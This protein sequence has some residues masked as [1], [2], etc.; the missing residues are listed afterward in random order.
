MDITFDIISKNSLPNEKI[1][2]VSYAFFFQKFYTFKI[3][4]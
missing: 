4:I 3:Y 2:N 1:I